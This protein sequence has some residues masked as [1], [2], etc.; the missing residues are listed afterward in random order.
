MG[1]VFASCEISWPKGNSLVSTPNKHLKDL[2]SF[3]SS[4]TSGQK[5][6]LVVPVSMFA[7][8]GSA[9]CCG[10]TRGPERTS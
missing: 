4:C 8:D 2:E 10:P 5:C 3:H 6:G 7:G 1:L 9:A